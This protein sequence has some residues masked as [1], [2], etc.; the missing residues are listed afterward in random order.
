MI[1]N[2]IKI[3]IMS[4]L[5]SSSGTVSLTALHFVVTNSWQRLWTTHMHTWHW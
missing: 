4:V 3:N 1:L 2:V 5:T